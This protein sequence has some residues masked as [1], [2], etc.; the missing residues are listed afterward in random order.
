MVVNI[1]LGTT[2][3]DDNGNDDDDDDDENNDIDNRAPSENVCIRCN[4]FLLSPVEYS[5]IVVYRMHIIIPLSTIFR[6]YD[7]PTVTY[8]KT[9]S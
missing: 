4:A 7:G 2:T 9:V 3:K 8:L 5:S 1:V 6:L